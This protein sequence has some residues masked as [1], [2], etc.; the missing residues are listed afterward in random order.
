MLYCYNEVFAPITRANSIRVI[1]SIANGMDMEIH[2]MDVKTAFLNGK[3]DEEIYMQQPKGYIDEKN[4]DHVRKLHK[5]LYGLKQAARCW[6]SVIDKHFKDSGYIQNKVDPCVYVKNNT[7][8]NKNSIMIIAIHVDGLILACND[9][10]MM[11]TKKKNLHRK[12]E[13]KDQGEAHHILGMSISRDRDK[14][15]LTIS[16]GMYLEN[17]LKTLQH[18]GL[19]LHQLILIKLSSS[20]R[21]MRNLLIYKNTKL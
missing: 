9:A 14:R 7:R 18:A 17:V 5:S 2:Q 10:P 3:L 4:P 12:F 16:Q 8:N 20:C 13:M 21:M 6:N 11:A 19:L 1:L 15:T